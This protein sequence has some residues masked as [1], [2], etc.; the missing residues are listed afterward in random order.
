MW[1]KK[2]MVMVVA[3][4]AGIAAAVVQGQQPPQ[5]QRGQGQQP[6]Q[7]PL[8]I[9]M[10]KPGLY[11]ILRP[12]ANTIA[13]RV[14]NE[15]VV[16]VD[17][18][19]APDYTQITALVKTVTDQPIKYVINTHHHGDHT[20]GNAQFKMANAQIL[21]HKNARAA[22]T[23]NAAA[24]APGITFTTE[25]ALHIGGAE[26]QLHHVGRGHTNGD[27][28]VYFPDLRVMS[29]GDLFV[30]LPNVPTID[31][32]AGGSALQWKPTIDNIL[33]FDFDRVIPG[34]GPLATKEDL[35]RFKT[36]MDTLHTRTTELIRRGVA[37]DQFLTQIKVD[38]L[39]WGL[40]PNSPFVRNA[41]GGFWDELAA[42]R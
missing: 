28:V 7:P 15:G 41:W 11:A 18:M 23:G 3:A 26:M 8:T 31:Y 30:V 34:H 5:G 21:G 36:R 10:V 17:D 42:A 38:D 22:M 27:A 24:G 6:A 14:T 33:K 35:A 37:K 4:I 2:L 32:A 20:G 12:G 40:N 1:T 9:E 19:F 25:A 13:V 29:T 39:G 16:L